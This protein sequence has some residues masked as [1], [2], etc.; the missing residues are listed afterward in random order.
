MKTSVRLSMFIVGVLILTI[1]YAN[2]VYSGNPATD[3]Y[4][5]YSCDDFILL[6]QLSKTRTDHNC[7]M[8]ATISEDIPDSII[9]RHLISLPN[10][11]KK[12]SRMMN[13]DGW[14]LAY[15][16]QLND[17]VVL[18]RGAI[19]AIND[20]IFD[21]AVRYLEEIKP[22]IAVG[23][24][25]NCSSGCCCRRCDSIPDPHPFKRFKN[26][27]FWTFLHNG[28]VNQGVLYD[29]I[30]EEYLDE[31]PPTGSYIPECD[32]SDPELIIDSELY[33]LFLL[34]E[35]EAANWNVEDGIINA[36]KL[37]V[38][39][40]LNARLNFILSD[41]FNIW[42]FKKSNTLFYLHNTDEEYSAVVSMHPTYEQDDWIKVED[43]EFLVIDIENPPVVS[44]LRQYLNPYIMYIPD[45]YVFDITPETTKNIKLD[46]FTYGMDG[47]IEL[48]CDSPWVSFDT[49]IVGIIQDQTTTVNI[50]FNSS[51][52]DYKT[53]STDIYFSSDLPGVD[54]TINVEMTVYPEIDIETFLV[55]REVY[56]SDTIN[57]YIGVANRTHKQI[58]A[59]IE[60]MLETPGGNIYGPLFGPYPLTFPPFN[61]LVGH[62]QHVVP[63]NPFPGDYKYLV[64]VA[65]RSD[66]AT[67]LGQHD[68]DF[69]VHSSGGAGYG[70]SKTGQWQTISHGFIEGDDIET[71]FGLNNIPQYITLHQNYP[72]P[73]NSSTEIRYSMTQ[74]SHIR[75][76]IYNI[77]GQHLETL[78][79]S[80]QSPGSY[81]INWN[82]R[83]YS[84]GIYF[85]KLTTGSTTRVRKMMMVK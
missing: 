60:T 4:G 34:K 27:R 25:R 15:Y 10:A 5:F 9:H 46:F 74:K 50:A 77:M 70:E 68:I 24:V 84:S 14:G 43:F 59:Y 81:S 37:L 12:L 26:N 64:K 16:P 11:L 35:I 40:A 18:T 22:Q 29:L 83:S 31:N 53:Y 73:F 45:E 57:A 55:P 28:S 8:W 19:R 75:V 13:T 56:G 65:S 17:S 82:P 47:F 49:N 41:G 1:G 61:G 32:P 30:G 72:N 79:D 58:D 71:M 42:S 7:R 6:E 51:M 66:M 3:E 85:I 80:P 48:H 63:E 36:I 38:Y 78:L 69:K 33:F 20:P 62:L 52:M 21:W 67:I 39:P 54:D 76:D 2:S 44:S 23:H